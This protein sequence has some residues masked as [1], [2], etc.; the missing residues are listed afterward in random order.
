MCSKEREGEIRRGLDVQLRKAALDLEAAAVEQEKFIRVRAACDDG[1][2]AQHGDV[3]VGV[4]TLD[5]LPEREILSVGL[6]RGAEFEQDVG[7][8]H[9]FERQHVGIHG[10][11]RSEEHTSE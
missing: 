5:V 8:A 1:Q 9:F 10:L 6:E 11:D 2:L 7:A 3:D 4:E